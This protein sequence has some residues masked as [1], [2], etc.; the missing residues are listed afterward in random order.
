[1]LL[2]LST[3]LLDWWGMNKN[4]CNGFSN[5]ETWTV[6]NWFSEEEELTNLSAADI[7]DFIS[8]HLAD[9][10]NTNDSGFLGDV[11]SGFMG[12]VNWNE[13]ESYFSNSES[14]E[15]NGNDSV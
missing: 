1:M 6:V 3:I 11:I 10:A 7:Q 2:Q 4:S 5:W 12:T 9:Y 14:E 15:E 8:W 13:L